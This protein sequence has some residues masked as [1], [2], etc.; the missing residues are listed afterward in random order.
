M[1][2][3]IILRFGR[4]T[5]GKPVI[6]GLSRSCDLVF[7]ILESMVLPRQ[8]AYSIMR[9][10]GPQR[11]YYKAVKFLEEMG[12]AIEEVPDNIRRDDEG[13]VH[14]GA[15]TAVCPS[16]A[17]AVTPETF[18]IALNKGKCVACGLCVRACPVKV[19]HVFVAE[20]PSRPLEPAVRP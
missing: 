9:L 7:T 2:K 12:V 16:G 1:E 5:W 11:E 15:C 19:M 3:T 4:H 20:R 8:E 17:L 13:C 18:K 10:S 6:Y 14:C